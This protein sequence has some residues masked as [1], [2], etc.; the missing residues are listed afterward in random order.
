MQELT[1]VTWEHITYS[2]LST[3][4]PTTW[5]PTT[6]S[7]PLYLYWSHTGLLC[8]CLIVSVSEAR[9]S[10]LLPQTQ[11]SSCLSHLVSFPQTPGALSL[12]SSQ[13]ELN[14]REDIYV[15]TL[16][17]YPVSLHR[18]NKMCNYMLYLFPVLLLFSP[19]YHVSLEERDNRYSPL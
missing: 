16:T 13:L 3:A 5:W 18:V 8:W 12:G 19:N 17:W 7:H 14:L 11:N 15:A 6:R 9:L 4:S 1:R 10:L 2:F